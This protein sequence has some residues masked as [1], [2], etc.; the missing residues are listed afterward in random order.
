M[1][2]NK[3]RMATIGYEMGKP[4]ADGSRRVYIMLSHQGRR[5][6][7]STNI[8]IDKRNISRTGRV[9]STNIQRIIDNKI[10]EIRNRLCELELENTEGSVEWYYN[11]IIRKK[12]SVD[13][14]TFAREWLQ[15]SNIKGKKNYFTMLN[16]LMRYTGK[17]TLLFSAIDYSFLEGFC[18]SLGNHHRAKSLYLGEIRHL[19]NE[20]IRKYNTQQ[21]KIIPSSPFEFF[22]IPKHIPQTHNRVISED[23]L[24]KIFKF[25]GTRRVGMARDCYI[26]SFCL[27][28][29]N[30]IDM[31]ECREY[32]K[33]ILSYNR[34]KT[35][36]RRAD[37]AYM[38][39][40]VPPIILPLLRKY[41][42]D[43]RVFDFYTRY[44]TASN[45]NKHINQGLNI[46]AKRLGLPKFDFCSARHTWASIARNKL[47]IDK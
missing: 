46:I 1:P 19:Y 39:I 32:S 37:N 33:G 16:S 28:G 43:T 25:Q 35:K 30:S 21:E 40:K 34:M 7:I 42:G 10:V 23:T 11:K 6:R 27:I 31:Y 22:K 2:Q 20:A 13:F 26:L 41:K 8:I 24:V 9:T 29:M 47:G 18:Y 36:D 4:K 5:K 3:I 45:F 38:E 17:N 12:E 44:T 15:Q 14:F